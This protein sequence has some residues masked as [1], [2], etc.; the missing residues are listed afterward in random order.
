MLGYQHKFPRKWG[1]I[2]K[3]LQLPV[4][5]QQHTTPNIAAVNIETGYG[6]T[7]SQ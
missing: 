1:R 7:S 6:L 5:E 4:L 2:A 3:C